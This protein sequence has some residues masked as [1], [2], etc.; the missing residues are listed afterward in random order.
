MFCVELS[1]NAS[2]VGEKLN[3][4]VTVTG[5]ASGAKPVAVAVICVVPIPTP[6]IEG[7]AAGTC[8]PFGI[9]TVG[10]TVAIDGL[11]LA[12]V[13]VTLPVAGLLRLTGKASV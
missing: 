3:V 6:V 2:E 10:V 4:S 8:K 13:I 11:L 9:T 1:T 12:N 7:F 5:L